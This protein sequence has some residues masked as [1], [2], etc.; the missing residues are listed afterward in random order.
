MTIPP[1]VVIAYAHGKATLKIWIKI[2]DMDEFRGSKFKQNE[3][4]SKKNVNSS[5]AQDKRSKNEAL[6]WIRKYGDHF[7]SLYF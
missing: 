2:I 7:C 4:L 5:R 3:R 1:K 6:K